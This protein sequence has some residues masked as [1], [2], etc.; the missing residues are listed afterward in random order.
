MKHCEELDILLGLL[1]ESRKSHNFGQLLETLL[2]RL[3]GIPWLNT[4]HRGSILLLNPR[5]ELIQVAHAGFSDA[6]AAFCERVAVDRC[7]CGQVA[8]KGETVYQSCVGEETVEQPGLSGRG[9]HF[10]LPIMN[11]G[12]LI[13]TAPIFVPPG[14][15]PATEQ[16]LAFMRGLSQVLS[17]II[18]QR[19]AS[20]MVRVKQL[21]LEETKTT[22]IQKLGEASE[23]K[24]PETGMHVMR[25]ANYSGAIAKAFGLSPE[26]RERILIVAPMH[27]VG[28]IGIADDILRK[29]G[30]LTDDE[31]ETMKSHATIGDK[32]L[33]GHDELM[34]VAREVARTHHEK[35]D[36]TGYPLGLK[37]E[38]I[39]LFGRICAI[40]DVFDAL[41]SVR[42][43]KEAWPTDKAIDLIKKE[44]G[45]SFDPK[46]VEAFLAAIP[47]ILRIKELYR[48]DIIDPREK[49]D[50]PPLEARRSNWLPW[51]GSLNI[52]IDIIDEHHRYLVDVTNDLHEA[53]VNERGSRKVGKLLRALEHYTVIHFQEEERMMRHYGYSHT[54]R[55]ISQHERFRGKITEFWNDLQVNPLALGH[56]AIFFLRDWLVNHIKKEDTQLHELTAPH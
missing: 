51:D 31:F 19:M 48:D 6:R 25:M 41:T 42:P 38:A 23:Y 17:S 50:L 18:S 14:R 47:E 3:E 8:L 53:V 12:V 45:L 35:W 10:I 54:E 1:K 9:S 44:S 27:D 15:G 4:A 7:A 22:I 16:E 40:A 37:G 36:G 11:D 46:L 39:P 24:D 30:R 21:E 43:Y 26:E 5:K 49:L 56:E 33:H 32:I 2:N 29:P 20:E 55:H 34:R 28:K 52:G 13:G